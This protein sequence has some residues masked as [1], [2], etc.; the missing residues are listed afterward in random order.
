M[1]FVCMR[2][3]TGQL[4]PILPIFDEEGKFSIRDKMIYLHYFLYF[5]K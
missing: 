5:L 4:S 2:Y 3:V 1:E